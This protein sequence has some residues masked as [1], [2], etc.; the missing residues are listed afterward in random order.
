M[1]EA[2]SEATPHTMI[3]ASVSLEP[4]PPPAAPS[5]MLWARLRRNGRRILG[6]SSLCVRRLDG[7][8]DF[9]VAYSSDLFCSREANLK[10]GV[11][12]PGR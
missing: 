3:V 7:H 2:T 1:M 5:G 12:M 6:L 8:Q 9:D 10:R 11:W 4:V